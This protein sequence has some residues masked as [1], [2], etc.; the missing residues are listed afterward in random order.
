MNSQVC[1]ICRLTSAFIGSA[2]P[3]L[4]IHI[5]TP[6]SQAHFFLY[7][8]LPRR[9]LGFDTWSG[10]S[11]RPMVGPALPLLL[12]SIFQYNMLVNPSPNAID[13]KLN[14]LPIQSH[15]WIVH[16]G[17]YL[18]FTVCYIRYYVYP[19]HLWKARERVPWGESKRWSLKEKLSGADWTQAHP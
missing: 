14:S 7:F 8:S 18:M 2:L 10:G 9:A 12:M 17:E 6:R 13:E 1:P 19:G 15:S 16:Y 5:V 11:S 3:C 4:I